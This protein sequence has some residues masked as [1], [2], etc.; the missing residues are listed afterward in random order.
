M[1]VIFF[2]DKEKVQRYLQ[3][4]KEGD[5]ENILENSQES[6]SLDNDAMGEI[7]WLTK[8]LGDYN[9]NKVGDTFVFENGKKAMIL[10]RIEK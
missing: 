5:K 9:I 6:L 1:K 3:M 10:K 4:I 7:F 8:V 2:E